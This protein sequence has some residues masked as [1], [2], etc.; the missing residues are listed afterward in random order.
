MWIWLCEQVPYFSDIG[1]DSVKQD[2]GRPTL[3]CFDRGNSTY[4]SSQ[5]PIHVTKL[6]F[7]DG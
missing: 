7:Y 3:C 5:T 2:D 1:V 4:Q 6:S